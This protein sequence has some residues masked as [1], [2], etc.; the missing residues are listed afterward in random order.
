M[1]K[2]RLSLS[3]SYNLIVPLPIIVVSIGILSW[4]LHGHTLE[5]KVFPV[6]FVLVTGIIPTLIL[7]IDYL[8]N[9][10]DAELTINQ[11]KKTIHYRRREKDIEY[12]FSDIKDVEVIVSFWH[13]LPIRL[14]SYY[15][16]Y[17]KDG[18]NIKIT[19]LS[20]GS[21]NIGGREA[22]KLYTHM[23]LTGSL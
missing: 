3:L 11:R 12:K 23:P 5:E 2:K 21:L 22:K 14:Y 17:T 4:I 7:H 20:T 13:F 6:M 10:Y 8:I 19:C 15:I 1:N 18:D 9:D 16:I